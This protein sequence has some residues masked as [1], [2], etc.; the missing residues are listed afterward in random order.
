MSMVCGTSTI[1]RELTKIDEGATTPLC[2]IITTAPHPDISRVCKP[3]A[4]KHILVR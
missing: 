1:I 4:L 3:I 2:G